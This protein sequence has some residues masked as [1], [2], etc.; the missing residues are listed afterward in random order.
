M[1]GE[2]SAAKRP[3]RWG[4]VLL[5][6]SGEAFAGSLEHGIDGVTLRAIA[7]DIVAARREFEVDVAIVVGGGNIWRGMTGA[8]AG[9]DR[10]Q[11]DYMG[12]LATVINALALQDTLEQLDQPTRVQTAIHMAQV[13][14]PYIRRRAIRH[15]EKGRVVIFAGG[16][17]NP[18]FTTDTTA[19]L[20]AVEIDAEVVLK[21]TH[22][23]TDGIYTADPRRDPSA[24]RLDHVSY[25]E[26][27]NRGLKVMDATAITLC[28]DND[29]PIV[30]FDL[31]GDGNLRALL[32]GEP[33][34]TL[35]DAAESGDGGSGTPGGGASV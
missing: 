30:V 7:E 19:A 29:L 25:L 27:L 12:M 18:F 14:E 2:A 32:A 8:G 23:G 21:G 35:V 6:L 28:M 1:N 3:A 22:G 20:R 34:G 11:A 9:M 33:V 26:V 4:R 10:A 15:L 13:A 31:L 16:T 17:G 24:T 5:K